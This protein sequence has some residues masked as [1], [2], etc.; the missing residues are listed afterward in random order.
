L[1]DQPTLGQLFEFLVTGIV[2][3]ILAL[4]F[5]AICIRVVAF[6]LRSVSRGPASATAA[7]GL[8][9]AKDDEIPEEIA[10]VIAAAVATVVIQPHHIVHI[11]EHT[12]DE[13]NWAIEGRMWHHAS[14]QIPP[15]DGR[16]RPT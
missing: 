2:V 14:H 16:G 7:A 4:Y 11:R 8:S 6:T 9:R 12:S 3:V 10:A 13:R 5:L 1:P 15:R